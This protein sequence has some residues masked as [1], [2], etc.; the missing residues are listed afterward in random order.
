MEITRYNFN[1]DIKRKLIFAFLS[2]LHDADNE[3]IMD[4]LAKISPDAVLV[5]G[6]FVHNTELYEKGIECL[7]RCAERY[8]TFCSLGN[9]EM[10]C[11]RDI[12]AMVNK[13]GAVLLDNCAT[14]F[15]GVNIGGLTSGYGKM[16]E[17]GHFDKS[18][19]PDLAFLGSFSRLDGMKILLSH[20]PEYYPRYIKGK[21][22]DLT[23]SG[24]AHGGQWRFFGRGV[25][26]PNQGIFPKYT[27]GIYDGRFIVSRGIGSKTR[28]PR[29]NN[30]EE[31]L[32]ITLS[33]NG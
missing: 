2:D 32:A 8:P 26:A 14:V 28:I 25:F 23:L 24:H 12:T 19:A 29:I 18:P 17:Q 33:P 6:D 20:H 9:H 27:S 15:E 16:S 10:K 30:K 21:D 3:P 22:I 11:D 31:I 4:A 1:V 13:S 5:G 7:K